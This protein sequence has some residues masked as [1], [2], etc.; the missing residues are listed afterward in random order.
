[1]VRG[2]SAS[3]EPSVTLAQDKQALY[4]KQ[5]EG[6]KLAN[7]II[8]Q[9]EPGTLEEFL[10]LRG[11]GLSAEEAIAELGLNFE[12]FEEP[13]VSEPALDTED[14]QADTG[15]TTRARSASV[16][17]KKSA[18]KKKA[19]PQA[20]VEESSPRVQPTASTSKTSGI[21]RIRV[22]STS[23]EGNERGVPK[24]RVESETAQP[25]FKEGQQRDPQPLQEDSLEAEAVG[26]D[27]ILQPPAP[28][29]GSEL[30]LF[31]PSE[32]TFSFNQAPAQDS[33]PSLS[34]S[35]G[36]AIGS[37]ARYPIG[38]AHISG[39]PAP[40]LLTRNKTIAD[41]LGHVGYNPNGVVGSFFKM[42]ATS[43]IEKVAAPIYVPLWHFTTEGIAEGYHHMSNWTEV[44]KR[45]ANVLQSEVELPP[46]KIP[47]E[48]MGFETF[49]QAA[50]Y[51]VKVLREI[52]KGEIDPLKQ[53]MLSEEAAI[54]T[55]AYNECLKRRL[56][57]KSRL[58][59][60]HAL[61]LLPPLS[62]LLDTGGPGSDQPFSV[63]TGH[64]GHV[65]QPQHLAFQY[66][67]QPFAQQQQ[68][69]VQQQQQQQAQGQGSSSRKK[70]AKQQQPFQSGSRGGTQAA[71]GA[72]VICGKTTI[73]HNF[74]ECNSPPTGKSAPF[75]SRN[76][77]GHLVRI[78]DG[79]AL[80]MRWNRT[81]C[82]NQRCFPHQC[83]IC[84]ATNHGAQQCSLV[85]ATVPGQSA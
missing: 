43:V 7:F 62:V 26:S 76:E 20:Q 64:L 45:L 38:A 36:L 56:A 59:A 9:C 68:Q 33:G 18:G 10:A 21:K 66:Q 27:S 77:A 81:S 2:I 54:W 82:G 83:S 35:I 80:C 1:M 65:Q 47:D 24:P 78:S 53:M 48:F 6:D 61:H 75:A 73:P 52:A 28:T 72:C 37:P 49:F 63:A 12:D 11:T 71:P 70:A 13:D 40:P 34:P 17:S 50:D 31:G 3:V 22:V 16:P 15:R 79:A 30:G 14:K 29:T 42:P 5:A 44:G 67:S 19:T 58:G 60:H 46:I 41:P 25:S 39:P 8:D 23:S 55:A 84:G 85:G 69:P 57:N 32:S 74:K 4:E 51:Q